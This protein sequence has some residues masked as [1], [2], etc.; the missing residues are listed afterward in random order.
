M[1]SIKRMTSMDEPDAAKWVVKDQIDINMDGFQSDEDEV[2]V[3]DEVH[4]REDRK[5]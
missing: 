1:C 3:K 5:I 4:V 2:Y